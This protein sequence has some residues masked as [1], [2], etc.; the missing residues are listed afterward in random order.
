MMTGTTR[1]SRGSLVIGAM[2]VF[3]GGTLFVDRIA[4]DQVPGSRRSSWAPSS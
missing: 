4:P 3:I 2:L 1:V